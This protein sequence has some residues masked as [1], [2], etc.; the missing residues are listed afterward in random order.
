MCFT[1]TLVIACTVSQ[2]KPKLDLT[3]LGNDL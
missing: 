3:D 2:T 1:E